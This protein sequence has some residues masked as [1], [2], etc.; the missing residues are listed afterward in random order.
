MG[1]YGKKG[2]TREI[3]KKLPPPDYYLRNYLKYTLSSYDVLKIRHLI[4]EEN[5]S[6]RQND[7]PTL[8]DFLEFAE[9]CKD[10]EFTVYIITDDRKDEKDNNWRSDFLSFS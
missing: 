5:L 1:Y 10:A 4:P 6:D 3:I 7:S 8:K 9:N 2:F